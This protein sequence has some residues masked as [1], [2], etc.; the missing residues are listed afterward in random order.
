MGL[1][2]K[3]EKK[4]L[5]GVEKEMEAGADSAKIQEALKVSTDQKITAVL[6]SGVTNKKSFVQ[7]AENSPKESFPFTPNYKPSTY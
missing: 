2:D 7:L 4:D 6:Q 1:K 5:E 3:T